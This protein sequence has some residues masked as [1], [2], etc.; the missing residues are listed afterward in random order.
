MRG[1]AGGRSAAQGLRNGLQ[2]LCQRGALLGELLH[3]GKN[4]LPP[5]LHLGLLA[6]MVLRAYPES[7]LALF[8]VPEPLVGLLFP[9]LLVEVLPAEQ[10]QALHLGLQGL[11]LRPELVVLALHPVHL[12]RGVLGVL[13]AGLDLLVLLLGLQLLLLQLVGQP[14]IL[15]LKLDFG[16]AGLLVGLDGLS[17]GAQHIPVVDA[18]RHLLQLPLLLPLQGGQ[19]LLHHTNLLLHSVD[20]LLSDVRIQRHLG[21]LGDLDLLLPEQHLALR[22]EDLAQQAVLLLFHV[23]DLRTHLRG[24]LPTLCQPQQELAL[25]VVGVIANRAVLGLVLRD[26]LVEL[27]LAQVHQLDLV[28]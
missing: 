20:F 25:E 15:P 7:V 27:L 13:Q 8:G 12:S 14:G 24:L 26:Q 1:G 16:G 9:G 23:L 5:L 18:P 4:V 17:L 6:L 2:V 10:S 19:P 11:E 3:N 22:L 21:L 28:L